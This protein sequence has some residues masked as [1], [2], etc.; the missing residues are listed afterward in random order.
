MSL[1]HSPDKHPLPLYAS[2]AFTLER[3]SL[4]VSFLNVEDVKVCVFCV[5]CVFVVCVGKR[6]S[7]AARED[8]RRLHSPPDSPNTMSFGKLSGGAITSF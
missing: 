5:C 4:D 1:L 2:C 8:Q 3:G 6:Q 7:S